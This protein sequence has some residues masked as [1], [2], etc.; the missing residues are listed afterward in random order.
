MSPDAIA[1]DIDIA[2]CD[3]IDDHTFTAVWGAVLPR[4]GLS[5]DIVVAIAVSAKE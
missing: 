3:L 1:R 5:E 4:V 2:T